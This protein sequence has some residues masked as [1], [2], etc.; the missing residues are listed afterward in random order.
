MSL[1]HTH[2]VTGE[3]LGVDPTTIPGFVSREAA[4]SALQLAIT[5]V[6]QLLQT[7]AA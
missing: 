6:Q 4:A 2:S 7:L 5:R 3:G 1:L